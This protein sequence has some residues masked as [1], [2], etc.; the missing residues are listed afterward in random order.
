MPIFKLFIVIILLVSLVVISLSIKLFFNKNKKTFTNC[1]IKENNKNK[2][3]DC[4]C[5]NNRENKCSF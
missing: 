4:E 2:T 1:S 5:C 3:I